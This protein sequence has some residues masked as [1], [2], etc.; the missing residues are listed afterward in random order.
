[1]KNGHH[2]EALVSCAFTVEKTLR[3]TL[4]EIVVSAGFASKNTTIRRLVC[5][6]NPAAVS[7]AGKHGFYIRHNY[8]LTITDGV[9]S[10]GYDVADAG[11]SNCW[12]FRD[13]QDC[14][15]GPVLATTIN[16]SSDGNEP[17]GLMLQLTNNVIHSIDTRTDQ[18]DKSIFGDTRITTN[19]PGGM[20]NNKVLH[21]FYSQCTTSGNLISDPEYPAFTLSGQVILANDGNLQLDDIVFRNARVKWLNASS[22]YYNRVLRAYFT[23]FMDRVETNNTSMILENCTVNGDIRLDLSAGTQSITLKS[24]TCTGEIYTNSLTSKELFLAPCDV[25]LCPITNATFIYTP[26]FS[27][28]LELF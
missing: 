20:T 26:R 16:I 14:Y 4:R 21:G 13:N 22:Y 19:S 7:V 23:E 25:L 5:D 11:V 27:P 17:S 24:V 12:K 2:P 8:A 6:R 28:K 18:S 9:V 10:T 1:M 3:R 15:V